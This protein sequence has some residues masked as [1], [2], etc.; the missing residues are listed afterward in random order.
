MDTVVAA[1]AAAVL[2]TNIV[3]DML[4]FADPSTQALRDALE[5]GEH[6]WLATVAMREELARVLTYPHLLAWAHR[7][8]RRVDTVLEAFDARS[9]CVP[10]APRTGVH[11]SDPDDQIF[12]DLAVAHRASLWSKDHAVRRLQRALEL[13]GV[14]LR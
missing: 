2:D 1:P 3:L 5:R 6:V 7:H 8:G 12:I 14:V 11:C 4:L 9:R 10:A 13:L